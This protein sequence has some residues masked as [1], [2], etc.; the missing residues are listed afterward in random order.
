MSPMAGGRARPRSRRCFGPLSEAGEPAGPSPRSWLLIKS[1]FVARRRSSRHG[2]TLGCACSL[3]LCSHPS[4]PHGST[5][6]IPK[7]GRPSSRCPPRQCSP[8]LKR[9]RNLR[10]TN[11]CRST[12]SEC[13]CR[14]SSCARSTSVFRMEPAWAAM[15]DMSTCGDRDSI[16]RGGP[17]PP[18]PTAGHPAQGRSQAP[19]QSADRELGVSKQRL[20]GETGTPFLQ[21]CLKQRGPLQGAGVAGTHVSKNHP[22]G[23]KGPL[24][25]SHLC[26]YRCGC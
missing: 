18:K 25:T 14:T 15:V 21:H 5:A 9:M 11:S 2:R 24:L 3:Q 19:A 7:C 12:W 6:M 10:Q 20:M 17:S 8:R 13:K 23:G 16:S 26:K 4:R 1:P 22:R